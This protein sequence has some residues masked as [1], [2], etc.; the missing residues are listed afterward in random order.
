MVQLTGGVGSFGNVK[1]SGFNC[2]NPVSLGSFSGKY[3]NA[4]L[5]K[6]LVLSIS[7]TPNAISIY[8]FP[9]KFDVEYN[10]EK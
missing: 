3:Y 1:V 8:F 6:D 2:F 4:L 9:P 10:G 5:E 7:E